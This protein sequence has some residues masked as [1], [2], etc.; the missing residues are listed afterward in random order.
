MFAV[1]DS[2]V[3]E[4]NCSTFQIE[5]RLSNPRGARVLVSKFSRK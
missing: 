4:I 1:D 3:E 2:Q 5:K